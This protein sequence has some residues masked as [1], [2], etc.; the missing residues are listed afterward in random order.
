MVTANPYTFWCFETHSVTEVNY[1]MPSKKEKTTTQHITL[2]MEIL[3]VRKEWV[4]TTLGAET[5]IKVQNMQIMLK[6]CTS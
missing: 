1:K 5:E 4:G 2:T 3:D 6:R